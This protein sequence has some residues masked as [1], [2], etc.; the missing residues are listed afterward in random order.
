MQKQNKVREELLFLLW[1]NLCQFLGGSLLT[2]LFL[3]ISSH[4]TYQPLNIL[5]RISGYGVY[6][7]LVTPFIIYW[8]AYI[9]AGKLTWIKI[10]LTIC[11]VGIYS[12]ILWDSYFFLKENMEL[13]LTV[14]DKDGV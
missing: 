8:L 11:L 3:E 10:L 9:S 4:I 1:E 7:Y 13:L 5:F 12:F 6:Y 2:Y 14:I